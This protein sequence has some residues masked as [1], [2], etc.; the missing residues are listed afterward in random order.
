MQTE[1]SLFLAKLRQLCK[2]HREDF[3][4]RRRLKLTNYYLQTQFNLN[5][6]IFIDIDK[7]NL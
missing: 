7:D 5:Q 3:Q 6:G 4:Q 2:V 1:V